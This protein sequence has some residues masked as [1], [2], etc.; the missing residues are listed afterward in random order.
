MWVTPVTDGGAS[1]GQGRSH[2]L[3]QD[4][5]SLQDCGS[6]GD[7]IKTIR[8]LPRKKMVLIIS[9]DIGPLSVTVQLQIKILTLIMLNPA[10]KSKHTSYPSSN[11]GDFSRSAQRIFWW[12]PH[13]REWQSVCYTCGQSGSYSVLV[14]YGQGS[15]VCC[16][17]TKSWTRLCDWTEVIYEICYFWKL[18]ASQSP[19]TWPQPIN[20]INHQTSSPPSPVT[21]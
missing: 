17:V 21:P 9:M 19:L 2:L 18:P 8:S 10:G 14:K 15:L 12:N 6:L 13:E 16:G 20:K 4:F 7:S 11:W 5:S 1:P 3:R